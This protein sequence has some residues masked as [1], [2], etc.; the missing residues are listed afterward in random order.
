M[1]IY[2]IGTDVIQVS[3][4]AA[5]MQRTN[6]RFAEKVLGPDELRVYHARN[7]RSEARGIAFLATR[8]SAKEA[9]SK[10]IGLGMHWP[11]TWRALQT[12]NEPSGKPVLKASGELAEWLDARGISARVTVS[13]ERD[14]AV[15]FVIAE[16]DK[17]ADEAA[18][19][20][21][22]NATPPA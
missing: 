17:A 13:D 8:F 15:A 18:D 1:A 9:F 22:G 10:A 2:G 21:A 19:K 6:G 5:V 7:A 11:M 16:S 4:V 20:S 12:L 14:Y 3:R